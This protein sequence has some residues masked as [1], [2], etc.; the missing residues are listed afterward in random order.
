MSFSCTPIFRSWPTDRETQTAGHLRQ[1][2]YHTLAIDAGNTR[3]KAGWFAEDQMIEVWQIASTDFG[4]AMLPIST[5]RAVVCSVGY[6]ESDLQEWLIQRGVAG[7]RIIQS[8]DPLPFPSDYKTPETLGSDRKMMVHA[9]NVL[10]PGI[11]RLVVSMGTCIT[12]DWINSDNR[13]LG[14]YITPG[15]PMRWEAMHTKTERLPL[16]RP[17]D[18][19]SGGSTPGTDTLSA[20]QWGV[21]RSVRHEIRGLW[22]DFQH[23]QRDSKSSQLIITGGDAHFFEIIPEERIFAAPHLAL[24]GLHAML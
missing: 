6:P 21:L 7:V 3:I 8:G 18:I 5:N 12:Y 16:V 22:T 1:D 10:Y 4:A 13:H 20:L 14:G 19:Q 17:P 23:H 24:I 2:R 15:L 9:A 11:P